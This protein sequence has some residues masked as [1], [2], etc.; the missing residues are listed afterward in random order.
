VEDRDLA[1]VV[2]A[3]GVEE[4]EIYHCNLY[5]IQGFESIQVGGGRALF[6]P[7]FVI[8]GAARSSHTAKYAP[9]GDPSDFAPCIKNRRGREKSSRK[10]QRA[11]I[12]G[13]DGH[14]SPQNQ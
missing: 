11:N 1:E 13:T 9:G 12:R 8:A 6:A 3:G 14:S 7:C 10:L 2:D 5:H 4:N